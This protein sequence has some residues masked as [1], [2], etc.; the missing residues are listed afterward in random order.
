MDKEKLINTF[1]QKNFEGKVEILQNMIWKFAGFSIQKFSQYFYLYDEAILEKSEE[2]LSKIYSS[3]VDYVYE[4]KLMKN[5][6]QKRKSKKSLQSIQK[7]E[8]EEY[9]NPETILKNL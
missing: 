4:N 5:V 6:F 3:I 7:Q 1:E 2:K 8:K 9:T